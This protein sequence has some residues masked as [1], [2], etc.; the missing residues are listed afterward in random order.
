MSQACK[1]F[2]LVPFNDAIVLD[3]MMQSVMHLASRCVSGS[4]SAA[5]AA[6]VTQSLAP[7]S[8]TPAGL[9]PCHQTMPNVLVVSL[10][11]TALQAFDPA[12]GSMQL[13]LPPAAL[14]E[15]AARGLAGVAPRLVELPF[16]SGA[17]LS[18]ETIVR[19]RRPAGGWATPWRVQGLLL[20]RASPFPTHPACPLPSPKSY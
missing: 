11:A 15:T 14:L 2:L 7:R 8:R 17:E 20:L 5:A 12:S 6:A 10:G 16:R 18:W 4:I 3:C 19:V 13:K 9:H 1:S